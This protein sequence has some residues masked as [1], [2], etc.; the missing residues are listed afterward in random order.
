[1]HYEDVEL[2]TQLESGP[3]QLDQQAMI[4]FARLWDPR[5]I[6]V[7]P[8]AASSSPFGDV[9]ACTAY[10]W[11]IYSQLSYE[12]NQKYQIEGFVAGLGWEQKLHRPAFAGDSLAMRACL[13]E[14]R[15]SKKDPSRIV[16][17]GR[18]CLFNQ[19]DELVFE[20]F[21]HCLAEA[22]ASAPAAQQG[23]EPVE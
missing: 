20:V 19:K 13:T 17:T 10:I 8:T 12:M 18:D 5:P 11:A 7:D 16:C 6:H 4:E 2:G 3:F 22:K 15:A 9:I 1:M 21:T 14:R 23:D